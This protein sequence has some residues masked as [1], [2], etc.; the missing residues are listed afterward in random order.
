M[1]ESLRRVFP[2]TA[3]FEHGRLMAVGGVDVEALAAEHGTPL[4]VLDRHELVSRMRAYREAFGDDVGVIYAAKALSVTGVLQLAAREGLM[5]DVASGGELRSAEV[6][7]VPMASVVFHG[8]NKS[9][10]ELEH[11]A[12]T[13]VGRVVVDS[14]TE[15]ERLADVAARTGHTFRVQLRVTPGV[16]TDTHAHIRTGHD[17]SKF[18]FTLSTGLA[19]EAVDRAVAL[20]GVELVGLHSHVGS[21]ILAGD[22]FESAVTAMVELLVRMRLRHGVELPELN[23]GGGLGI[24]YL[25]DDL[26]VPI[27]EYAR[28]LLAAVDAE[29]ASL[30]VPRPRLFVEPGRSIAGPAGLTLY[31]VG[32]VK[33]IPG[34]NTYVAIDG[35]MSDN[36]RPALY[37]ARYEFVPA[38]PGKPVEQTR[39]VAIAGKHCETGDVLARD[40]ALPVDLAEGELLAVAA[41]GA[42]NQAMASNYNRLP[43]PAMVLAGDGRAD[44]LL[45]RETLDDLLA[46][47]VPLP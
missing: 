45:R 47:D 36:P 12:R 8:N 29:C 42:Y 10:E 18:G 26:P 24:A 7:G 30:G 5:V 1:D 38:G 27:E 28:R 39:A 25:R 16:D 31:R 11:A 14:F 33:D 6:A 15:L 22:A 23:L 44:L 37:G 9:V 3:V 41:T 19:D 32:T 2:R 35:G 43:R 46:H 21:Q 13:G 34:V 40:V 4:W 20:P 17:D